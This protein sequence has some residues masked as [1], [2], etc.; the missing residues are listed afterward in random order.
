MPRRPT[1]NVRQRH[2]RWLA[3]IKR[4]GFANEVPQL[5]TVELMEWAYRAAARLY[6][7]KMTRAGMLSKGDGRRFVVNWDT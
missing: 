7:G 5:D 1:L 3:E 2:H 6:V 4:R